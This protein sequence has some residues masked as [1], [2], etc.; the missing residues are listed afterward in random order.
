MTDP[1]DVGR[2][3]DYQIEYD[4]PKHGLHNTCNISFWQRAQKSCTLVVSNCC[5]QKLRTNYYRAPMVPP[6]IPFVT[7]MSPVLKYFLQIGSLLKRPHRVEI[8][9][10]RPLLLRTLVLLMWLPR[11][12]FDRIVFYVSC[13]IY[14]I[15]YYGTDIESTNMNSSFFDSQM[16][17]PA[18]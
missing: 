3:T 18:G 16:V 2:N 14:L 7:F 12:A 11:P 1:F 13:P 4:A 6:G 5:F 10:C 17:E 9:C 15:L 8:G